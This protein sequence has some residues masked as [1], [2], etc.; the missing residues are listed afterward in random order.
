[1]GERSILLAKFFGTGENVR[2]LMSRSF[3]I[4][5]GYFVLFAVAIPWY[6]P[7]DDERVWLGFPLW[8]VVT[9]IASLAISIYTSWLFL[10]K[11]PAAGEEDH[12]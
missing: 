12:E 3:F 6:W 5:L 2:T 7:A 10:T 8:V 4:W 9:L 1:M 11:W